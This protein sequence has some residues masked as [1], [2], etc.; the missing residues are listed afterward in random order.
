MPSNLSALLYLGDILICPPSTGQGSDC[1]GLYG[2]SNILTTNYESITYDQYNINNV[3]EST[4]LAQV[5]HN[6]YYAY[7]ATTGTVP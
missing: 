6:Q 4:I 7:T 5:V 1:V 2:V 3:I